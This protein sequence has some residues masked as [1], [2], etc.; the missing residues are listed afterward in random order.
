MGWTQPICSEC[1]AKREP[2]REPVRV[3]NAEAECCCDCG[4]FTD[5]GIY[6]RVDPRTVRFPTNKD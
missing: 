2:G 5:E 3:K 6:Y 1:Y 4:G